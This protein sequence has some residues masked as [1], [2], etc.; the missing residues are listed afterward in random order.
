[1]RRLQN[2]PPF[3]DWVSL[4]ASGKDEQQ[5]LRALHVCKEKLSKVLPH[6]SVIQILGPVPMA[7]VKINDRFRYRIQIC[8]SMN[9]AVRLALSSILVSCSQDKEM[10]NIF[11]YIENE[12]E[13]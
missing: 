4:S 11:F 5:L 6:E 10:R 3:Y 12:P 9:R 1:M 8:C 2:A 7:V 13:P